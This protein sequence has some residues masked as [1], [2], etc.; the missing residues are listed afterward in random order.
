MSTNHL[1][2]DYNW[3][4]TMTSGPLTQRTNALAIG[5]SLTLAPPHNPLTY[6]W[7]IEPLPHLDYSLIHS[8]IKLAHHALDKHDL[9]RYDYLTQ[10]R[11]Y[12]Y[13][14]HFKFQQAYRGLADAQAYERILN[15]E[16]KG[17][18]AYGEEKGGQWGENERQKERNREDVRKRLEEVEA[19]KKVRDGVTLYL[20]KAKRAFLES[21]V[22]RLVYVCKHMH[23]QHKK[24]EGM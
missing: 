14:A 6:T 16:K 21:D 19:A 11:R 17:L 12:Y 23:E 3:L 20:S 18:V 13:Q 1:N 24:H 4:K 22:Y 2:P 10:A 15:A 9:K 8:L 5:L 7:D